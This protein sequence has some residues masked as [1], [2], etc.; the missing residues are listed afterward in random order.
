MQYQYDTMQYQVQYLPSTLGDNVR[1]RN[2][3]R[4]INYISVSN[5]GPFVRWFKNQ[6]PNPI[7]I[8]TKPTEHYVKLGL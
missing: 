3:F 8:V 1:H 2:G 7:I 4:N 6:R 5:W